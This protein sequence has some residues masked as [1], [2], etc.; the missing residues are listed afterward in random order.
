MEDHRNA[1]GRS[2]TDG[3]PEAISLRGFRAADQRVREGE[4]DGR[5]PL[6]ARLACLT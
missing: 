3:T 5:R 4:R 2:A 1:A 6:S